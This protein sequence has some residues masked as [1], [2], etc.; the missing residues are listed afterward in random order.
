[1]FTQ[2]KMYKK[3]KTHPTTRQIYADQLE[4]E[5]IIL[6]GGGDQLVAEENERLKE[7]F[8][9]G[10]SY[11]PNKADTLDGIWSGIKL[12]QGG[13]RRGETGVD[14]E[15]LRKIGESLCKIPDEFNINSKLRRILLE[16]EKM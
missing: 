13:P 1:M 11:K 14:I 12:A 15:I 7:E 6:K 2:P 4:Q 10:I 3:I 16:K 8:D 5:G 9:A